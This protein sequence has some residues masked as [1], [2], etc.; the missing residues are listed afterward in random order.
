MKGHRVTKIIVTEA[1]EVVYVFQ[2][3]AYLLGLAPEGE[4]GFQFEEQV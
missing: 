4:K 2:N 3:R 1:G